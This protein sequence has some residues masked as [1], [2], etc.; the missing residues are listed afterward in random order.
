MHLTKESKLFYLN[1]FVYR[2]FASIMCVCQ[3]HAWHPQKVWEPLE[4]ELQMDVSHH[5]GSGDQ[6]QVLCKN[7]LLLTTSHLSSP[8]HRQAW[9]A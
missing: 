5:V 1:I 4:L 9:N 8:S 6:T 2:H 3:A 7:K